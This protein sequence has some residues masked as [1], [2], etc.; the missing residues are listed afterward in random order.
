V[1]PQKGTGKRVL[2]D[3]RSRRGKWMDKEV[4]P[5]CVGQKGVQ[6]EEGRTKRVTKQLASTKRK[7]GLGA[8]PQNDFNATKR[9]ENETG[10][11]LVHDRKEEK[12][13]I[14]KRHLRNILVG[15]TKVLLTEKEERIPSL[16]REYRKK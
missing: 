13:Q 3:G 4:Y 12:R 8:M 15:E 9:G 5:S 14:E 2:V 10:I 16:R 6:R 11:F 1:G 7:T